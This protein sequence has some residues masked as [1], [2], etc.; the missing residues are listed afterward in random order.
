[1]DCIDHGGHKESAMTER[2][3]LSLTKLDISSCVVG[4]LWRAWNA[5][6]CPPTHPLAQQ[7]SL[8][9]DRDSGTPGSGPGCANSI[10]EPLANSPHLLRETR[11]MSGIKDGRWLLPPRP[12]LRGS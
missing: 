7:E 2:L 8:L 9:A 1:M 10:I 6:S 3:L 11:V 5:N 12:T 4:V